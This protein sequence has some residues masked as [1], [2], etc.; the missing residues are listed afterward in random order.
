MANGPEHFNLG[1]AQRE[2]MI[3]AMLGEDSTLVANCCEEES[4]LLPG[5]ILSSTP[6]SRIISL[7]L[8]N[9]LENLRR[10]GASLF[11]SGSR[12][13]QA[14]RLNL[15]M[16]DPYIDPS[17]PDWQRSQIRFDMRSLSCRR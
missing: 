13:D 17:P 14:Q 5:S 15:S 10:H 12:P 9:G 11:R 2:G 16:I 6:A 3:P 7:F 1:I 4:C 8:P